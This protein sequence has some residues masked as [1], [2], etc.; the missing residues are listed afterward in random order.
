MSYQFMGKTFKVVEVTDLDGFPKTEGLHGDT[1]NELVAID[2]LMLGRGAYLGYLNPNKKGKYLH[3]STVK[4]IQI[5]MSVFKDDETV[6][7]ITR[8]TI[9]KLQLVSYGLTSQ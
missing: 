5:A 7:I 3:T 8:N 1:L 2:V 6:K 9:Y 4:D